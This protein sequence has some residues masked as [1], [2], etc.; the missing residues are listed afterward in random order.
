MNFEGDQGEVFQCS[1]SAGIATYPTDG[2]TTHE[3]FRNADERLYKAKQNGRSR[4]EI[5]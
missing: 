5:D 2:E 4:I 3:L 1:F